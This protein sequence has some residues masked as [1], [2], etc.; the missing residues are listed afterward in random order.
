MV[1]TKFVS[2]YTFVKLQDLE[3]ENEFSF[4]LSRLAYRY[5]C[6]GLNRILVHLSRGEYIINVHLRWSALYSKGV[7]TIHSTHGVL[8]LECR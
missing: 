2:K 5:V 4:L 6:G 8:T 7:N 3:K 1:L